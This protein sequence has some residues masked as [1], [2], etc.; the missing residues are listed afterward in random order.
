MEQV[1]DII[2]KINMVAL[3]ITSAAYV[4]QELGAEL[5]N[6]PPSFLP[7]GG[8][9]LYHIQYQQVQH[10]AHDIILSLPAGFEVTEY[11]LKILNELKIRIIYVDE[12]VGLGESLIHVI[13]QIKPQC[14]QLKILHGDTLIYNIPKDIVDVF[15]VHRAADLYK[16]AKHVTVNENENIIQ[17]TDMSYTTGAEDVLSGFFSF[18][19]LEKFLQALTI[20]NGNFILGLNEYSKSL[21]LSPL[22]LEGKWLDFGH[23][24]T[25]YKSRQQLTT[26][27]A[28]NDLKI[29][30]NVIEKTGKPNEKI[31]AE[32][33]WYEN[34]P[35]SLRLYTPAYLGRTT[36]KEGTSYYLSYEYLPPLS[37]LFVFGRL[38]KLSWNQIF[39][40][41]SDFLD[42]CVRYAAPQ[43]IGEEI[44][45]LYNEKP[46]TR[47][48]QFCC[49]KNLD[50]DENWIIDGQPTPSLNEAIDR[51]CDIL[52]RSGRCIPGIM[53]GDFCFSNI[54]YDTRK[55]AIKV[56]DPRGHISGYIPSLYGDLRYD[57]AKLA[58]SVVARYDF[59]VSGCF[60]ITRDGPYSISLD[61]PDTL[62]ALMLVKAQE[63]RADVLVW[64]E[65]NFEVVSWR[66]SKVEYV[67]KKPG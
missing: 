44:P 18:S 26:Q 21:P 20:K 15:S 14:D 67:L 2:E 9:R 55:R 65:N 24:I 7:V 25:Y 66:A 46:R 13:E 5:G 35:P 12:E 30:G 40:A 1:L 49:E 19:S 32:A 33:S 47:V 3:V 17:N 45:H 16:W 10:I 11:D 54:L 39:I 64:L 38:S 23:S 41:C 58:H 60:S 56:V 53:H 34:I 50:P 29:S 4:D 57:V 27:R 31:Q 62:E 52:D 59:I 8:K 42:E 63:D 6:I 43:S 22:F 51:L 48:D 36:S 37:D 61:M 28:F